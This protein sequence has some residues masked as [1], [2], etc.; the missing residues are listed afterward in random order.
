LGLERVFNHGEVPNAQ[1]F[2]AQFDLLV[3]PLLRGAGIRVK[4][5]EAMAKGIPVAT[6]LVGASGLDMEDQE[7]ILHSKPEDMAQRLS[8]LIESPERLEQMR[9]SSI[10]AIEHRFDLK[11]IGKDLLE[12]YAKH[13][14]S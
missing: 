12:F 14:Q 1:E 5:V 10:K 2:S 7:C 9:V 3:V 13:V 4:I 8:D 11:K 6:T